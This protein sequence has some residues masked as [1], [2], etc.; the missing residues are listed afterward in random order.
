MKGINITSSNFFK[1]YLEN[2]ESKQLFN[3]NESFGLKLEP[4]IYIYLEE[5]LLEQN[6]IQDVNSSDFDYERNNI[7]FYSEKKEIK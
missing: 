4:S 5:K 3:T 6:N 7:E 2:L 1:I